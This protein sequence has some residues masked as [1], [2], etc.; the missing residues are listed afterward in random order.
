MNKWLDFSNNANKLSQT[1][2]KGFVDI[3]YGNIHLRDGHSVN[4][5]NNQNDDIYFSINSSNMNYYDGS[6]NHEINNSKLIYINDLS[7]NVQSQINN[8]SSLINNVY[9][10]SNIDITGN[11]IIHGDLSLNSNLYISQNVGIGISEPVAPLDVASSIFFGSDGSNNT[12]F[13]YSNGYALSN[14]NSSYSDNYSILSRGSILTIGNVVSTNSTTF[15]DNRIKENIY[16]IDTSYSLSILRQIQPKQFTY[17]DRLFHGSSLNYGFIAQDLEKIID[18]AVNKITKFIPNIFELC[19][20]KNR[21][22][23][24]L[25]NTTTNDLTFDKSTNNIIKIYDSN[26]NEYV[27]TIEKIINEKEFQISNS[28]DSSHVFVYG[29]KIEDFRVLDKDTIFTITTSALKEVDK[30]LQVTKYELEDTKKK[31]EE[32]SNLVKL[33]QKQINQLLEYINLEIKI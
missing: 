9:D 25:N 26:N 30:E 4:L 31:V 8:L 21:N 11:L 23:V 7:D 27:V 10:S 33:Q 14:Q 22:I 1:Y 28:F 13:N 15:S 3:N 24:V 6:N 17:K 2:F 5:H 19:L 12:Y 29:Q 32:L 16:E 20:I 18:N